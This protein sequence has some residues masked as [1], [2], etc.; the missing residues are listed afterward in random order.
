MG[1]ALPAFCNFSPKKVQIG[2]AASTVVIMVILIICFATYGWVVGWSSN[3]CD[4]SLQKAKCNGFEFKLNDKSKKEGETMAGLGATAFIFLFINL[5]ILVILLLNKFVTFQKHMLIGGMAFT[6][7]AWLFLTAG[8]GRYADSKAGLDGS[9][10]Y[11]ASFAFTVIMWL[12]LFPYA[13]FWFWLFNAGNDEKSDQAQADGTP[14]QQQYHSETGA[15]S[16]TSYTANNAGAT[17]PEVD[18]KAPAGDESQPPQPPQP[19]PA[20]ADPADTRA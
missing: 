15:P 18:E 5:C 2:L 12:C 3:K 13:F 20:A 16:F 9:V 7:L 14:D 11:G 4:L 6:A 19:A 1:I 17:T 10:D 8:W